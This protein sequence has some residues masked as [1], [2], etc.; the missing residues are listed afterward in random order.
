MYL[1]LGKGG[2]VNTLLDGR[3]YRCLTTDV[4]MQRAFIAPW[5]LMRNKQLVVFTKQLRGLRL[6]NSA[7]VIKQCCSGQRSD[8]ADTVTSWTEVAAVLPASRI[9]S[10]VKLCLKGVNTAEFLCH[11]TW[12]LWRL[13]RM[14]RQQQC[15]VRAWI[16]KSLLYLQSSKF[17]C[18][19]Y[20]RIE[21]LYV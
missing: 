13:P 4:N 14:K 2:D 1:H 12:H 8:W 10:F 21:V 11:S 5:H 16:E 18:A 19:A 3:T 6:C 17:T 20:T 15:S 9:V 7:A